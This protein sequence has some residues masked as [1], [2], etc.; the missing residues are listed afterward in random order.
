MT[1]L[2]DRFTQALSY[3]TQLHAQQRRKGSEIPYISHLLSV[4]ALVLEDGGDEDSAI[5]ALLHDAIEDQ[6]GATTRAQI[7]QLFGDRVT[8]LINACTE[9]ETHPKPPWKQRKLQYLHQIN[10]AD[11]DVIRIALADKLH[12]ARSILRDLQIHPH[13]T[14]QKFNATPTDIRWFYQSCLTILQ[15]RSHSPMV[16]ELAQTLDRWVSKPRGMRET[17]RL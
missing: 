3:A 8:H 7:H 1:Q 2:T 16:T 14:W 4:T 5:A 6:G 12:N 17:Q 9:S 10:V 11:D 13:Q 15:Q